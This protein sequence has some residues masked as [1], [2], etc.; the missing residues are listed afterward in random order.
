MS[1][2]FRFTHKAKDTSATIYI[3]KIDYGTLDSR[4]TRFDALRSIDSNL[5]A[6]FVKYMNYGSYLFSLTYVS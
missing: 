6:I 4:E 1:N 3:Y 2:H 5:K